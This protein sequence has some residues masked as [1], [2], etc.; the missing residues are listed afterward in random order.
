MKILRSRSNDVINECRA[1]FGR[2]AK[3]EIFTE[4]YT[5]SADLANKVAY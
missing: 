4:I 3:S 2:S 1:M 5:H